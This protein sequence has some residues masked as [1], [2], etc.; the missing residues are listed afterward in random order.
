MRN[1]GSGAQSLQLKRGRDGA[2]E[3]PRPHRILGLELDLADQMVG[4][5]DNLKRIVDGLHLFVLVEDAARSDQ[6]DFF[7][8]K[9]YGDYMEIYVRF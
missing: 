8:R 1:K 9:L 2:L 4:T 3:V 6:V 5:V 7:H